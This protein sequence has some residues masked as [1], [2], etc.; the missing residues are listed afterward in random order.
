MKLVYKKILQLVL[1]SLFVGC[2]SYSYTFA[3]ISA[4]ITLS[5]ENPSPNS[6][7]TL[8]LESYT[9]DANTA[10]IR[11][12]VNGKTVLQG[13]GMR[14]L[15]IKTGGIGEAVSVTVN[16]EIADGSSIQQTIQVTPSSV[17]LLYEAQASYVPLMY[18]GR[19]LPS[20]GGLVR[21]TAIPEI[22]DGGR[23]M[24]PSSLSFVWYLNDSVMRDASGVGK[25]SA[26]FRLDFLNTHDEI[27][28]IVRSPRGNS[29]TKTI[30]IYPHPI[31]PLLYTYDQILGSDFS[32][33]VSQRFET[34]KDFSLKLEPLYVSINEEK[35]PIYTWFLD[36]LP[37]TPLGGRILSLHPNN[38]S[39]GTKMLG[40]T[41]NGPD[42]R[43]QKASMKAEIIFDTRK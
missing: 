12:Q 15:T 20:N 43:I 14:S 16:A 31:M 22:S 42:A 9:F 1:I 35:D 40:I 13:Q 10:I 5:P 6:S 24:S 28:V 4:D 8:R 7:V 39:F 37:T 17:V 19:S 3:D 30:T 36:G 41:I 26:T 38:N 29:A 21:V 33:L 34:T 23:S 18:A 11:W 27:K 2:A 32:S 25:Q